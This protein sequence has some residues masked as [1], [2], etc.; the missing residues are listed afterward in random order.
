MLPFILAAGAAGLLAG[1]AIA[2]SSAQK[3]IEKPVYVAV[4]TRKGGTQER[5]PGS[6]LE[7]WEQ[8]V[9]REVGYRNSGDPVLGMQ[10]F[11]P[12]GTIIRTWLPPMAV[13]VQG[14]QNFRIWG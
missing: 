6:M 4:L 7:A 3:A 5:I 11:A 1:S 2:K 10:L 9:E 14:L 13:G 12:G 8:A